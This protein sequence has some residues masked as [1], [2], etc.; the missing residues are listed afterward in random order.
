M[1]RANI[2]SLAAGL[3]AALLL[4]GCDMLAKG[5]VYPLGEKDMRSALRKVEP[6]MGVMGSDNGLDYRVAQQ[7]DGTVIWTIVQNNK[8][9]LRFVARSTPVDAGSTRVEV[10]ITGPTD[11]PDDAVTKRLADNSSIRD[12][13]LAAMTEEI[14]AA[15][16]HRSFNYSAIAAQ[17]SRAMMANMSNIG[18][19][20]DKAA[21]EFDRR[22]RENMDRAY[23]EEG[24]SGFSEDASL[25]RSATER[26]ED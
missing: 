17:T 20:M 24:Q 7:G 19:E 11:K 15:L 21:A 4:S 1:M 22:D 2:S 23:R 13:Y 16:E 18:S 25:T 14:D 9:R 5:E 3:S 8:S 6:P 12:L 10:E 26:E